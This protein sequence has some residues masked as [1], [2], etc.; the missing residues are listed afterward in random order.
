MDTH[1]A[2]GIRIVLALALAAVASSMVVASPAGATTE[3][4]PKMVSFT[5]KP[6]TI[7]VGQTAEGVA[8][9][10]K[11]AKDDVVIQIAS[12][13]ENVALPYTDTLTIPAGYRSGRVDIL[14]FGPGSATITATLGKVARSAPLTVTL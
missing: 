7:K 13:D 6:A 2:A 14:G 5:V 4:V 12:S 1:R 10:K 9:L 3:R 11:V 8:T